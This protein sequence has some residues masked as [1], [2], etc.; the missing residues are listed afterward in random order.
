MHILCRVINMYKNK[1]FV[2]IKKT[3]ITEKSHNQN[4]PKIKHSSNTLLHKARRNRLQG[5]VKR[6]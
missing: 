3:K 5:Q 4:E 6:D 2:T 1:L